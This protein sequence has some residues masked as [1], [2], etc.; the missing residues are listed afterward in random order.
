MKRGSGSFY[1][2][3]KRPNKKKNK[4]T[5]EKRTFVKIDLMISKAEEID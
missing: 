5:K 2:K 1:K 3:R 4:E